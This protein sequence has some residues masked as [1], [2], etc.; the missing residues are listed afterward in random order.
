MG[1][2]FGEWREAFWRVDDEG[3]VCAVWFDVNAAEGVEEAR[4]G[5]VFGDGEG[6]VMEEVCNLGEGVWGGEVGE[7]AVDSFFDAGYEVDSAEG[8]GEVDFCWF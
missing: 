5:W 7:F 1:E 2:G 6:E 4:E 3:R 8:G